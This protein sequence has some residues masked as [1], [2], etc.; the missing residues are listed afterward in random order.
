M[1]ELWLHD[2]TLKQINQALK[3]PSHAYL[4][5]GPKALGKTTAA[6]LFASQLIASTS[7]GD[8]RRWIMLIEPFEGKKIALSQVSKIKDFINKTKP[9]QIAA[10]VVIIDQA[11]KLSPE[12][13]NA[14][15]LS[16]EEPAR[17]S[18]FILVAENH[19]GLLDTILSRVQKIQ[20]RKMPQQQLVKK[21]QATAIDQNLVQKI[22]P[23]P[24]KLHNYNDQSDQDASR[25][26]ELSDKFLEASLAERLGLATNIKDKRELQLFLDQLAFK[27]N[28]HREDLAVWLQRSSGLISAY[29]HLYNN[30]NPKFILEHLAMEFE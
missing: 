21:L 30:G 29:I 2:F 4:F 25:L 9:A 11:D 19:F 16:L 7:Q 17:D 5:V 27:L 22:G 13:A 20:F 8:Q 15:L 26:E 14:L 23:Y 10:K 28:S 24:A 12:A 6:K 18:I 3:S 1:Y